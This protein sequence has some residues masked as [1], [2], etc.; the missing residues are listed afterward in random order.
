MIS[1]DN[2]APRERESSL[3]AKLWWPRDA[4]NLR[5]KNERWLK[6]KRSEDAVVMRDRRE[7]V[8]THFSRANTFY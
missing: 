3:V 2:E 4:R 7:D 8:K 5:R 6:E 1:Y